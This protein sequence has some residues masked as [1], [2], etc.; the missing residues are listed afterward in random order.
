MRAVITVSAQ[1]TTTS[2]TTTTTTTTTTKTATTTTTTTS[3]TT[4]ST[5]SVVDTTTDGGDVF[6]VDCDVESEQECQ[7]I[8][9][10]RFDFS[11]G[12]CDESPCSE[13]FNTTLCSLLTACEFSNVTQSCFDA[14]TEIPCNRFF[15]NETC[16]RPRCEY[17]GD[18]FQCHD[19][20]SVPCSSFFEETT[21]RK[22]DECKY[23]TEALGSACVQSDSPTPCF[24]FDDSSCPTSHCEVNDGTCNELATTTGA[25]TT[26][27]TTT[28]TTTTTPMVIVVKESPEG[29]TSQRTTRPELIT[30]TSTGT[31]IL[32]TATAPPF[33]PATLARQTIT[34]TEWPEDSSLQAASIRSTH[35][36]HGRRLT[37][38]HRMHISTSSNVHPDARRSTY[39][40]NEVQPPAG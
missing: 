19:A 12:T 25:S 16:P 26:D 15:N 6:K 11:G 32:D 27:A 37:E 9:G 14:G 18:A 13:I 39:S 20:G 38:A 1:A 8:Q 7:N 36:T 33:N 29:P 24:L 21:C 30:T 28:T 5:S 34:L 4:S 31:T 17:N 22:Y 3:T 23:V 40:L 35:G 2:T 10:C